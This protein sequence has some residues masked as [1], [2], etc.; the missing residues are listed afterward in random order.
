MNAETSLTWFSE[1]VESTGNRPK[2]TKRQMEV[3][4]LMAEGGTTRAIARKLGTSPRTITSHR[5]AIHQ[6]LGTHSV[7][8]AVALGFRLG[9]LR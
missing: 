8:E 2:L 5:G 4:R 7:G 6:R 3:F 9:L 1:H